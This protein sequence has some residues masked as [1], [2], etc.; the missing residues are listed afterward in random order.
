MAERTGKDNK[1][2]RKRSESRHNKIPER[3]AD[4][5]TVSDQNLRLICW[6]YQAGTGSV[7]FLGSLLK[8]PRGNAYILMLVDQFTKWVEC[9]PLPNQTAET[10]ARAAVDCFFMRFGTAIQILSDQGRNFESSLI[11][12]LCRVL[13]IQVGDCIYMLDIS[14]LSETAEHRIRC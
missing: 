13:D 6:R 10:T 11:T 2:S 8:T 7:D 3:P 14:F 12:E 4:A 5:I 1:E 9:I